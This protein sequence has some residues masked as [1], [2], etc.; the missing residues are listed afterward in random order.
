MMAKKRVN[1]TK[2][3]GL[4]ALKR[5]LAS[6]SRRGL[7]VENLECRR[8]LAGD[9]MEPEP[10]P[11]FGSV[12][13]TKWVDRDGN[14]MRGDDEPGLA[15]VTIYADTNGNRQ[16]DRGEPSTR[17]MADDLRTPQDEAGMYWLEGIP[18]GESVIREVVPDGF[19]QT[20]PG[21]LPDT[22]GQNDEFATTM[23]ES[24]S[25]QLQPGE[26][27]FMPVSLQI[28]PFCFRPFDVDVTLSNPD[29]ELINH[30]GIQVNGCGGDTTQFEIS[31]I[32]DG[33]SH[34]F[35]ILF[36][37]AEF[38]GSELGRIPVT[39][40]GGSVAY[41]H[42]V[43]LEPNQVIEGL[44]FGNL[45][46][47]RGSI[48]G[49]KWN[50]TNRNGIFDRDEQ[51][52]GGV[53]I[54]LD[55]NNNGRLDRFEP[56]AV[57][58]FEDPF[59]DFDE[60]GLYR[61]DGLI[62][63]EHVVREVVPEG[64]VQ[65][66][67]GPAAEVL[68]SE[69]GSFA[70]GAA[71]DFEV[72]DVVVEVSEEGLDTTVDLTILWPNGCHH[73]VDGKTQF[74]VIGD[75]ILVDLHGEE[76]AVACIQALTEETVSIDLGEL[77]AGTYTVTGTL[78][79][80][81]AQLDGLA[82]MAVVGELSVGRVDG[83]HLVQ[84][85][86]GQHISEI[87]FGN[88]RADASIAEIRGVK[89]LDANG[90]EVRDPDEPGLPGV[91]IFIDSNLNGEFD[92]GEP[93]AV[94]RRDDPRTEFDETGTYVLLVEAG[95]HL[96]L[97]QLPAGFEQIHPSPFRRVA[98]PYNLGHAVEVE[99][100]GILNDV[101][102]GNRRM[103]E[104][105]GAVAGVKWI[106]EDG[107]GRQGADEPLL[108]GVTIFADLNLNGELDR[109][110]PSAVTQRDNPRTEQDETGRYEL[111]VPVG[112]HLILEVQPRRFRQV[113]PNP[114]R[115][116]IFPFNLGHRV[117]IERDG[118][119]VNDINFGN[120]R[121][122]EESA[123][124]SGT[125]W[126]DF[127]VNGIFDADEEPIPGV[128]IYL[129]TNDNGRLDRGEPSQVTQADD[130]N[131]PTN[132]AG[133]YEFNDLQPGRYIVREVI[134]RAFIQTFPQGG[135]F[136]DESTSF[137]LPG[138]RAREFNLDGIELRH[139]DNGTIGV[140]FTFGTFWS[141]DCGEMLS[142]TNVFID[143]N[144]IHVT[145]SSSEPG[146]FCLEVEKYVQ[147]T[148]N[149][150]PLPFGDFAVRG[151]L[152]EFLPDGDIVESFVAEALFNHHGTD[153]HIV[154]LHA[155]EAVDGLNFGNIAVPGAPA[156]GDVNEDLVVDA[157]DIDMLAMAIRSEEQPAEYDLNADG[158]VDELDYRQL[159]RS[160]LNTDFG[161]SNL[162]GVFDSGDLIEVFQRGEYEDGID[163][164]SGWEDGDWN[165]DGEFDS[166]DLVFVFQ[167]GSYSNAVTDSHRLAAAA[168]D[169][170]WNRI[171]K[172]S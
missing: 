80:T 4:R 104:P 167:E 110:E 55:Q 105:V 56:T 63:G 122:S 121:I 16:L 90:N 32:G 53:T 8:L 95:P 160:V 102:F 125:K 112:D 152:N 157:N 89:W 20:F 133:R 68:S 51:G 17:T 91:T 128:T 52:V 158:A 120:Q 107:D 40:N 31:L 93:F 22:G 65:T 147:H 109:G 113:F 21:E 35:D 46:V 58:Q 42:L 23:P 150:G 154:A 61:F 38:G 139:E 33:R 130:P 79:E 69:T 148:V 34:S 74:T 64:F 25:L 7:Q 172:R 156:E 29:I 2:R 162:D 155:G 62:E 87:N 92:R 72:S 75:H 27:I 59:T 149:V 85:D 103:V 9:G 144:E 82:T 36:V 165:G 83:H 44:D 19:V 81:S 138:G 49:R 28:H 57:T 41:G 12:H 145:L 163:G 108:A 10:F 77:D 76:T 136:F 123:S 5:K 101:N 169:S 73:V 37:D 60:G 142:E 1:H 114:L 100:G 47:Q 124:I 6:I 70:P 15:G 98:F 78:H 39:I 134:P 66:F 94:T 106:D 13:G 86:D 151:V 143:G 117:T 135:I 111:E 161:D 171:D 18:I 11:D 126:F 119:T 166:G 96:V 170:I 84:L 164:N 129:D 137:D 26:E 132:E 71:L 153:A 118:Q 48:E 30:S 116:I 14:G 159:V 168:I 140:E 45:P 54:Y 99:A 146:D 50:D 67:P 131:T 3:L 141:S 43:V 88:A 115:E 97:E 127:N 24:V